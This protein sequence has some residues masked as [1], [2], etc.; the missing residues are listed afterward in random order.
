MKSYDNGS[1]SDFE[2]SSSE[3]VKYM[4][5]Y[6]IMFPDDVSVIVTKLGAE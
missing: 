1:Q 3:S 5:Y 2:I 6:V 4:L